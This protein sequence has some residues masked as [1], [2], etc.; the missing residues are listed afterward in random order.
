MMWFF[1]VIFPF[2]ISPRL[3]STLELGSLVLSYFLGNDDGRRMLINL[4]NLKVIAFPPLISV[5]L[6]PCLV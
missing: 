4:R 2:K 6:R 3:N 5:A 1:L